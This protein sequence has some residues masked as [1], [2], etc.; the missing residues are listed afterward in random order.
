[1]LRALPL[2]AGSVCMRLA[3]CYA[4]PMADRIGGLTGRR[5]RASLGPVH[6]IGLKAKGKALRA[7]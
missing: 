1:M 7:R 2:V 4:T 5:C 3:L 6:R